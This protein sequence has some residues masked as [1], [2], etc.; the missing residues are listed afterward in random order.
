MVNFE[1][2]YAANRLNRFHVAKRA[3]VD[4]WGR[5]E[6][7]VTH[8]NEGY[9]RG[10]AGGIALAV[11]TAGVDPRPRPYSFGLTAWYP[12]QRESKTDNDKDKDQDK[13]N[14]NDNDHDNDNDKGNDKDNNKDNDKDNNKDTSPRSQQGSPQPPPGP[15][16]RTNQFTSH[17]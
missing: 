7:V 1:V 14:D 16:T 5:G 15:T 2:N 4:C 10:V 9:H 17:K 3:A 8:C 11:G 6:A 12:E 13:D